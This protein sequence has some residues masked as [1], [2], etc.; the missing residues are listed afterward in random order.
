MRISV[1]YSGATR[2]SMNPFERLKRDIAQEIGLIIRILTIRMSVRYSGATR[3]P[4]C[5]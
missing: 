5:G 3:V 2:V 1:R 4:Q